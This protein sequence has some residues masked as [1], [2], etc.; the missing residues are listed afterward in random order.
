MLV[1]TPTVVREPHEQAVVYSLARL[2]LGLRH[3][4][5]RERYDQQAH[6][7]EHPKAAGYME[8]LGNLRVRLDDAEAQY[9][10]PEHEH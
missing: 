3:A 5:V 7:G 9:V 6:G 10:V 4:K 1:L 8:R 2:V